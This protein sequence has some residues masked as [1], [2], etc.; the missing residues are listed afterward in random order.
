VTVSDPD[1]REQGAG[2]DAGAVGTVE[3][4]G[5]TKRFGP[6]TAL[7][8]IHL[9]IPSGAFFSLLGPSGCGKTTLLRI[10]A[11]LESPDAGRVLVDGTD[12]TRRPPEKRPFN[13][14]FQRYALFPH[15]SVEDNV[16]FGLTTRRG[17]RP[18]RAE[19]RRRVAEM[20]DL[21]GLS[22]LGARLPSELSGGQAQRV[23]VARALIRQ[24][25][26]LLLDEP[27]SA[28]DRNVR[29]ALREELLRIHRELGTT[30]LLVTHDQD[31]AL[32]MSQYVALMND[33]RIE[34]MARPEVLYRNPATLFAARFVGAGA[35]VPATV[36]GMVADRV[37][38]Q[39]AG[40]PIRAVDAGLGS[41][42]TIQVLLRP[43]D[44]RIVDP[45]NGT[46]QGPVQTCAFFGS[47]YELTLETEV[48]L[49]R[50]RDAAAAEPGKVVA[51]TWTLE[52]GIAYP[53]GADAGPFDDEPHEDG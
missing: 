52:A 18:P 29:H 17:E 50:A 16:A 10:L 53:A 5:V 32:S 21:V 36:T 30:F 13:I 37:E 47:Y 6:V 49:V 26:V 4:S 7:D 41:A 24:P 3:V 22:G 25:R 43:E 35:F 2:R 39:I 8:D 34:Q 51:L 27:L 28:L 14:V 20:L 46:L 48:G 45:G 9:E 12:I 1:P 44:L 33:G 42:T 38:A 40:R 31:E 11:G 23:A 19:L 15:L